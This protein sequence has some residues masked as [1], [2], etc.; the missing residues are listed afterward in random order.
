MGIKWFLLNINLNFL[1]RCGFLPIWIGQEDVK[2][3]APRAQGV[4]VNTL[5]KAGSFLFLSQRGMNLK[6]INFIFGLALFV[7]ARFFISQ[8]MKRVN[9]K[10]SENVS[11]ITFIGCGL[12]HISAVLYGIIH[13]DYFIKIIF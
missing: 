8:T 3:P 10:S 7:N 11:R 6:A 12:M 1:E 13:Q 9:E 2:N 4:F 5:K